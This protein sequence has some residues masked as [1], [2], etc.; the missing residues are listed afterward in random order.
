MEFFR[1]GR[2][3]VQQIVRSLVLTSD[4]ACS[5]LSK[6]RASVQLQSEGGTAWCGMSEVLGSSVVRAM[7]LKNRMYENRLIC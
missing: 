2:A 7:S 5:G 6:H 4:R 3:S 1:G